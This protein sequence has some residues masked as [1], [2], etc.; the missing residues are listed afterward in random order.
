VQSLPNLSM[1][2]QLLR[3]A[4]LAVGPAF[5]HIIDVLYALHSVASMKS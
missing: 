5:T 1:H 3:C 4:L 2:I